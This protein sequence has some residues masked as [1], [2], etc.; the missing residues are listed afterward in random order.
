MVNPST[1]RIKV[2]AAGC[3]TYLSG[4]WDRLDHDNRL[5]RHISWHTGP[6]EPFR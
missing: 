2:V 3:R 6:K 1:M 5:T 4:H